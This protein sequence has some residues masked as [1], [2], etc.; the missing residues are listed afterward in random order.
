MAVT[1]VPATSPPAAVIDALDGIKEKYGS[2]WA[3][4]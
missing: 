1:P 4:S 2:K 3:H